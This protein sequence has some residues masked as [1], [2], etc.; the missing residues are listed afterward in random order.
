MSEPNQ[1]STL[2]TSHLLDFVEQDAF[3][4]Y[5][6]MCELAKRQPP[7]A[8]LPAMFKMFLE[9]FPSFNLTQ[10]FAVK[11]SV[12]EQMNKKCALE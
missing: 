4:R 10:I 1:S 3:T 2:A 11:D 12:F 5:K 8:L 7:P 6:E 9:R